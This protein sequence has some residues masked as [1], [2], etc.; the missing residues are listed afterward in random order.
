MNKERMDEKEDDIFRNNDSDDQGHISNI[1]M[2][3]NKNQA[4]ASKREKPNG[5]NPTDS[6]RKQLTKSPSTNRS[7]ML[8][9]KSL[10]KHVTKDMT[11][12]RTT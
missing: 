2:T 8:S 4:H 5:E 9:A 7:N 6:E 10:S 1:S 11:P 3:N 12:T